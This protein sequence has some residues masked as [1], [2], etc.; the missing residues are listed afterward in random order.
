MESVLFCRL[1]AK[2]QLKPVSTL[3]TTI[4]RSGTVHEISL[5]LVNPLE[6]VEFIETLDGLAFVDALFCVGLQLVEGTT[7][8]D[9]LAAFEDDLLQVTLLDALRALKVR[10]ALP[11]LPDAL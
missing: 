4:F 7:V 3:G 6:A 5:I 11:G 8:G 9:R 10:L 2:A 1:T